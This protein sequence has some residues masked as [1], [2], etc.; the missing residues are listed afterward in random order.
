MKPNKKNEQDSKLDLQKLIPS[1]PEV[2]LVGC[3]R[4]DL[5]HLEF[6]KHFLHEIN[7]T[8]S[9]KIVH[10]T[11]VGDTIGLFRPAASA[12]W[13]KVNLESF[14]KGLKFGFRHFFDLRI[15]NGTLQD[16]VIFYFC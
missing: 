15:D 3:T 10:K 13:R 12:L 1:S 4:K 8:V 7:L 9:W 5:K 6:L 16:W 14:L 2:F 11:A